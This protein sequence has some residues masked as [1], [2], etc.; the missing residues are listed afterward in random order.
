LYYEWNNTPWCL[1]DNTIEGGLIDHVIEFAGFDSDEPGE[2]DVIRD[3][4]LNRG[5]IV[6][7]NDLYRL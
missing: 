7:G 4:L 5:H 6:C 3:I 1:E 2:V